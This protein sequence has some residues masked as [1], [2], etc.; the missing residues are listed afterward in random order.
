MRSATRYLTALAATA[1]LLAAVPA[2]AADTY[3]LDPVHCTFLF[4]IK[5]MGVS[6]TYGRFN[7]S[8]GTFTLDAENPA[9]NQIAVEVKTASIDTAVEARD[10]HLRSPEFFNVEA[11]P[12]MSFESTSFKK[13]DDTHFEVTGDLTIH[14][15]TKSITTT[16]EFVGIAK[17]MKGE[18]RAGLETT[19]T[20]D[21]TDF[22]MDT[23]VGPV[24]AEV[25]LTVSVE[26][27]RQ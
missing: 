21:R 22:G 9:N 13:I 5:H 25:E 3:D 24:G 1:A 17:G 18:T 10:K 11:F 26:G 20:I 14:G 7:E 27:I 4:K 15:V 23:M 16:A 2:F 12:T 6:Y 19:F 8:S